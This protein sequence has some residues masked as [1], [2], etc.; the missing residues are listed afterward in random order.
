M[1][2]RSKQRSSNKEKNDNEKDNLTQNSE[3]DSMTIMSPVVGNVILV[4][5]GM[6]NNLTSNMDSATGEEAFAK[7]NKMQNITK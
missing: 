5:V 7:A 3:D 4:A 1:K 2:T 6:N